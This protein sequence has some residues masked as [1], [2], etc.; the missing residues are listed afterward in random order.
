V[1]LVVPV[2]INKS[3]EAGT[4]RPSQLP[5]L[6]Q[7]VSIR[8]PPLQVLVAANPFWKL[9]SVATP[10][11]IVAAILRTPGFLNRL[12]EKHLALAGDELVA[13]GIFKN[14]AGSGANFAAKIS[15]LN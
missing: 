4:F 9:T 8:L 7:L 3:P 15:S 2:K 1:R 14:I 10:T 6:C 13:R 11:A 5:I 12:G